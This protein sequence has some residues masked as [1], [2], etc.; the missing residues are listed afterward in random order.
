MSSKVG[1][2]QAYGL[3]IFLHDFADRRPGEPRAVIAGSTL[4]S[5]T[6]QAGTLGPVFFKNASAFALA[7]AGS[8]G[9]GRNIFQGPGFWYRVGP[10]LRHA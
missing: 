2:V 9:M 4:P 5:D 10:T 3:N 7:P 8:T 1:G 6:L